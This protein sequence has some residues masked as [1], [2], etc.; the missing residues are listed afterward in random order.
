LAIRIFCNTADNVGAVLGASTTPSWPEGWCVAHVASTGST[1][2]DL[3]AAADRLTDRSVLVADHQRAGRGRL[4]RRWDAP[5]GSNLLVSLLFRHVPDLPGE[6]TRRVG[7]A[8]LEACDRAAG[9]RAGLKWPNDLVVDSAKLAGILAERVSSG[10]VVVGLGLN[11]RWA[12]P[13]AARL[14][15]MIEPLDVLAALLS[16]YDEQPEDVFERYRSRLVTLGQDVRVELPAGMIEGRAVDLEP[17]GR[18]IVVDGAG[19]RHRLDT[20]D[21]VHLRPRG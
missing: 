14:G 1:N 2:D 20:G 9:V 17:D 16:A 4:D 18:L 19:V 11:V 15:E 6:L 8:A 10:P 3:A 7:L 12:P 21:V 5:P 13:G